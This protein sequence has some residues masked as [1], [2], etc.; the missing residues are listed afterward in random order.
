MFEQDLLKAKQLV[1]WDGKVRSQLT[2]AGIPP[3]ISKDFVHIFFPEAL[4]VTS[5]M[6]PLGQGRSVLLM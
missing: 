6:A 3:H 1:S 5:T 4:S 2:I